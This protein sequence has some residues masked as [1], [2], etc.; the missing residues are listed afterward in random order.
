M[1][2]VWINEF[3]YDNEGADT[4]EF[5]E[6]AGL[7][8]LD[9]TGWKIV[10]YNGSPA[11]LKPYSTNPA[12]SEIALSG[13]IP[14]QSNGFGTLAFSPP[15]GTSF[16]NGNT[17]HNEPDGFALVNAEGEVVEFISYEGS[18]TAV[19]AEQGGGVAAGMTST[20][21]G[22]FQ[23]GLE[24][25]GGS[26]QRQ[27]T[28]SDSNQF[29][30]WV[31]TTANTSGSVNAGQTFQA[32]LPTVSI[33]PAS[34][35]KAEG[36]TGATSFTFTVTRSSGV[37]DASVGW[38]LTGIGGNGQASLDDFLG[39][40]GGVIAGQV[41][42]VDGE[43]SKEITIQVAGDAAVEDDDTFSVTLSNPVGLTLSTAVAAGT[44]RNDDLPAGE[45]LVVAATSAVKAEGTADAPTEFVFTV[46]RANGV[47]ETAVD[48]SLEGLGANGLTAADF[49]ATS[50]Q[51]TFANG[52]TTAQIRVQVAA[53]RAFEGDEP[54]TLRIATQK[55]G[56]TILDTTAGGTIQN[57]D[58]QQSFAITATEAVK[59]EGTGGETIFRFT[60]TRANSTGEAAT[61]EYDISDIGGT[62][63]AATGDFAGLEGTVS[64]AA[65]E[66]SKV[67]EIRVVGDTA[68]EVNETFSVTLSNP[69]AGVIGTA[70]ASGRINNDDFDRIFTIQGAG[71]EAALKGQTVTTTGIVTGI[72]M[73]GS[74]RGF[75]IQDATGDGNANTSD[76]IFVFMGGSWT[77]NI[78]VGDEVSVRGLVDEFNGLTQITRVNSTTPV[79]ISVIDKYNDL[80]AAVLLGP[81]GRMLSTTSV[82]DNIKLYESLE[83]MR[84]TVGASRVV[85]ATND[86]DEIYAVL[87]GNYDPSSLNSRGG[88]SISE[89][90]VNPERIQFDNIRDATN[91]PFVDVGA[92][93]GG[94][95][96]IL[97]YGFS[98]YEILLGEAPV[99]TQ[100]SPLTPEATEL[101][102][103]NEFQLTFGT[104]NI[105]NFD[106]NDNDGD[107][108]VSSGRMAQIVNDIVAKMGGPT[109]LALQEVQDDS[110]ST[111]N[112]VVSADR[113]L[114]AL[115]D[116]I[117]AAGGPTYRFAYITPTDNTDGGQGGANIRQAFLYRDDLVDLTGLRRLTDG[118]LTNGDAFDRSRKPLVG[119]FTYQGETYTFINNH[120]NSKGG[121][122]GIYGPQQPPVLASEAQRIEQAK[123]INAEVD[124]LLGQ[125]AGANIVVLGDLN[126]FAWSNPLKTLDGTAGG[127]ER[128]LWNAA[129]D[130]IADPRDR[131]DYV[132]EGNSQSLDHIYVSAALRARMEAVDIL[133]INS[134]FDS[135]QKASDHDPLVGRSLFAEVI[136]GDALANALAGNGQSNAIVAGA[137]ND[138]LRGL[139]GRDYLQG[140]AGDDILLGGAGADGLWGGA[141]FDVAS[142]A[143]ATS[144]VSA[145][146]AG[147][148]GNTGEA[149][150][151][152][153]SQVEGLTGSAFVDTLIGDAFANLLDGGAGADL[154]QGAGGDDT[155]RVDSRA[156][157]VLEAAGSGRDTVL[158]SVS[159]TLASSQEIEVL[160]A[161]SSTS[162]VG[163]RLTG[164]A[165]ANTITGASG[166]DVINGSTGD[167]VLAGGFAKDTLT[168]GRG[169]DAF[170]FDTRLSSKSNVDKITDF[171]VKD[172]VIRL[173]DAIFT[174]I[175]KAGRLSSDAFTT[176]S[177]AADREDR[178][179]YNKD[180]G[181]LSYDADGTG[182]AKAVLIAEL[183]KG[184]SL[185]A[186][187]FFV[188]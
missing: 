1:A 187:D 74:T 2:N 55:S 133:R 103:E 48:W 49:V 154:L 134:E 65:N 17:A 80:P 33:A 171:N 43:L 66:T 19:S 150:G 159:F 40:N 38:T 157:R 90:D 147:G 87:E 6:I 119:E 26:I 96:G 132:Y 70:K 155:Y 106:I 98:N 10:L 170:V 83:G 85:G 15:A 139:D 101:R 143:E 4:G 104:Y 86:F 71:P 23:N 44:I 57:D 84:V 63:Q 161:A 78:E 75:Y 122:G 69:S 180:T 108:D 14:N 148:A 35:D 168:G 29:T 130:L 64:F 145:N 131:T 102:Q 36:S 16:Q 175:G 184:L 110:G 91:L 186:A 178:M 99:V 116:A 24:A 9:L 13:V 113:N 169:K 117:K 53:D 153:Y 177:R 77:P 94:M 141:G 20:N 54:F 97:S 183:K 32:P 42:F 126:D 137:G 51:V 129:E 118:D 123:I 152:S 167:D 158:T 181:A 46:T 79:A 39:A 81:G 59:A 34:A 182:R 7:A 115:V 62:G 185:T 58:L 121:D 95:T 111:D 52:G 135:G 88:L 105:E 22:A 144:G 163:L 28:G 100:Q 164:N 124:R 142:Y 156:D 60:V 89:S 61:I 128:V 165:Y 76:A 173:D 56:V 18:F 138:L 176:G 188:I 27:G 174:K 166:R 31:T 45:S 72:Q 68:V 47:G 146:L 73:T 125:N 67:I 120:L 127:G 179:I 3:H 92:Q 114:Q 11:Q 37:G 5:I 93:L 21:V 82:A 30:T 149:Q 50:G 112:G 25:A 140:D 160:T 109:V 136:R 8:G 12:T 151:D 107:A 41:E 162:S 172:D